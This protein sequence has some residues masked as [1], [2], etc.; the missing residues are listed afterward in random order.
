[1]TVELDT[2]VYVLLALVGIV[3]LIFLIL[4]IIRAMSVVKRVDALLLELERPLNKT[5]QQM[6]GLVKKTDAVLN[7][8]CNISQAV[9]QT[10]PDIIENV[11]TVADTA[12]LL[13]G[14]VG[15]MATKINQGISAFSFSKKSKMTP[16]DWWQAGV[17]ILTAIQ[18]YQQ[19]KEKK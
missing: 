8:V 12:G 18:L 3:G 13:A 7:D 5:M 10:V 9:G 15:A 2:L 4:L 14:S 11:G 19:L 1:M 6:P 17:Q 16:Q